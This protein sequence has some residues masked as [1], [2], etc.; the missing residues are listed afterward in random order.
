MRPFPSY[1]AEK[2]IVEHYGQP[3]KLFENPGSG[4]GSI[5]YSFDDALPDAYRDFTDLLE[6]WQGDPD[7]VAFDPEHPDNERLLF[8]KLL[9]RLG[10]RIGHCV[11]PQVELDTILDPRRPT[12]S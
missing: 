8:V 1:W 11:A 9:D 3:F 5:S 4:K 12:P 10:P 6:P 2:S 7:L